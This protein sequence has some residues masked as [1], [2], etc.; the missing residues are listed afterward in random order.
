M[1][2]LSGCPNIEEDM[3]RY[4]ERWIRIGERI[5]PSEFECSRH[6]LEYDKAICAFD[7]LRNNKKIE[8]FGNK[9]ELA[10]AYGDY[11]SAIAEFVKRP[12]EFARR[13]DQL[14]RNADDKTAIID[15][16][17]LVADKVSTPVL[18][19][20]REHFSH[21]SENALVGIYSHRETMGKVYLSESYRNYVVPFSQRSASKSLKTIVR[22]SRLPIQGQTNVIRAFIWWT[23][24]DGSGL[25]DDTRGRVDIDLSAAMFDEQWN[26]ME[27]ISYTHLKSEKYNSCHSG[28]IV[29]G[30]PVDAD[31][32]Q[33][34]GRYCV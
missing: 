17:R 13:L 5:H 23:N 19:Q 11:T 4:K 22:G 29:N 21:R 10:L 2:L 8:T 28:D 20:L 33:I 25:D 14:L 32:G 12:G 18:L 34:G 7:N 26:Y 1:E 16:F 6:I 9:V 24:M 27:H 30:G 3:L 15:S 31:N